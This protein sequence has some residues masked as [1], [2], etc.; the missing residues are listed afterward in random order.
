MTAV[1]EKR[2]W[3]AITTFF[4]ACFP[5]SFSGEFIFNVLHIWPPVPSRLQLATIDTMLLLIILCSTMWL[6]SR[7]SWP[8]ASLWTWWT[9]GAGLTLALD[10]LT[11]NGE[12][13]NPWVNLLASLGYVLSLAI[14]LAV[15]VRVDPTAVLSGKARTNNHA[16]K[17]FSGALP[18]LTGTFAAYVGSN[19]WHSILERSAQRISCIDTCHG[20]VASE[21]FS[22]LSQVIPLLLVA[23]GIEAGIFKTS[24][25]EP[26]PRAMTITTVVILCVAEVLALSALVSPNRGSPNEIL[27]EWHEY[28]TF[29]VTWEAGFIALSLLVWVLVFRSV[30]EDIPGR[31]LVEGG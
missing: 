31:H 2:I 13:E 7:S 24:L 11:I 16:W 22:S 27:S 5:L 20:A 23:V 28:L 21:Y 3:P 9:I 12:V 29:F 10:A 14:L 4:I 18:L 15:A 17:D 6:W 8:R 1:T 19:I 25:R 30:E 26:V